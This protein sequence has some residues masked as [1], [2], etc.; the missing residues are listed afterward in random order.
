MGYM[1]VGTSISCATGIGAWKLAMLSACLFLW[2]I[3]WKQVSPSHEGEWVIQA[4]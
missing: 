4:A 1:S 2:G 3:M